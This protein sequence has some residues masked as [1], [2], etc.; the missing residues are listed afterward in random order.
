MPLLAYALS[1]FGPIYLKLFCFEK[2]LHRRNISMPILVLL[3]GLASI[4]LTLHSI[5]LQSRIK[6]AFY[7]FYY[8]PVILLL[9]RSMDKSL[10]CIVITFCSQFNW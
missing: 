9:L 1:A 4:I 5:R 10:I 6:F 8:I 2:L 7:Y 3:F